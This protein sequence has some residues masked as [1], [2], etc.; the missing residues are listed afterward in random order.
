M[1][2]CMY[3]KRVSVKNWPT[4]SS[5]TVMP[6]EGMSIARSDWSK[7][8]GMHA[9]SDTTYYQ[10]GEKKRH[11][12]TKKRNKQVTFLENSPSL[13]SADW[14]L[15]ISVWVFQGKNT[16][17]VNLKKIP[18]LL[19]I[20]ISNRAK[21]IHFPQWKIESKFYTIFTFPLQ[22]IY[23]FIYQWNLPLNSEDYL[24][25]VSNKK[26]TNKSRNKYSWTSRKWSPKM[27]S[28]RW[29]LMGGGSFTRVQTTGGLNFES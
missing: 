13:R 18:S 6:S 15:S 25:G 8:F 27:L 12:K 26:Q 5:C 19:C 16:L 2:V 1:Y 21:E 10:T 24:A 22:N 7:V 11:S 17:F 29:L 23:L 28:P 3:S 4:S 20:K 14:T 9:L